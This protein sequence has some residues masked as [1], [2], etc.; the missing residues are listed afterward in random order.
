MKLRFALLGLALVVLAGVGT[1]AF[2]PRAA[3]GPEHSD[4][5]ILH[6]GNGAEPST[7]DPH[8]SAGTWENNVIGELFMGLYTDAADGSPILGSAE[9][10]EVSEDGLTHTFT[11]REGLTWSDG[12]PVTAGDFEFALHR[13][14]NPATAAR[15]ASILYL[16]EG[17]E[18]VNKGEE[19]D[20][21]TI[22][23]HAIDDRTLEIR[24][25]RPI[26]FMPWLLTHV[27]TFPVPRHVVEAHPDDWT[28]PRYIV[29]NGPYKLTEWLPNDHITLDANPLFYDAE[30]VAI[31]RVIY[32]P[33][34]DESAALRRFRA[35]E[36]DMNS[37]FP[38][39]QYAWLQENMPEETHVAPYIGTS[40]LA[41]NFRT[42]A[43]QDVRVR[44]ALAMA[45][46]RDILATSVLRTGQ[47]PA[48]TLVP[49]M[50]PDYTPPQAFFAGWS[51][52][53]RIERAQRLMRDAG[54][55]P[56]NLLELEFRY[57]ESVD[58]RRVAVALSRFWRE[59]YVEAHLINTEPAVHYHDLET[60]DFDIGDAG[61]IADYPDPENYLF[62]LDTTAGP[63]NYGAYSNPEYDA[64]L[65]RAAQTLDAEQRAEILA[66][67]ESLI[68]TD[69]P[70]I[71]T[72]YLVSRSL[73][74]THVRGY[75]D[76]PVNIHRVRWMSI[77][78]EAREA[79]PGF[80]EQIRR[81]FN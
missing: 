67:A 56:D 11:I 3:A 54:F 75:E 47:T 13:I 49:P 45:I 80:V 73:V 9:R 71:P 7:I 36:L 14:L 66:E 4:I 53:E 37:G 6:R 68:L 20:L 35:G 29:S 25:I 15:Y 19:T 26:P 74:G 55:G 23:V 42:E 38:S 31:G 57:R 1:F 52:D 43:L 58:Q 12:V 24:V 44:Q 61:W 39:Q 77:D 21:S 33:T 72:V 28:N 34:N 17:A 10:H 46:N 81:W 5:A 62:L 69:M 65:T 27:T 59:I 8:R 70:L 60:G 64:L 48:Y 16:I 2:G 30:N 79:R 18:A 41:L 22:G 76:N 51:M 32:Y 78:E 40:Y 63:L 50:I